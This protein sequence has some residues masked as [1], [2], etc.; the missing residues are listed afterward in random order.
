M[1]P[2]MLDRLRAPIRLM[3]LASALAPSALA[4]Q[5]PVQAFWA[6]HWNAV[7]HSF[8]DLDGDG[9]FIGAGEVQFHVDPLSPAS[10]AT[11][12]LQVTQENGQLV[13]YWVKESNDIIY[14]GVDA[15]GNGTLAGAEITVFR[16]SGVHDGSSWP[17]DID[18]T[19]DGA[20]WWTSGL[21][22]S[23]PQNGLARLEDL[24]D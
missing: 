2:P 9:T 22:L 5:Q 17:Q 21:L 4:Q 7:Y 6:D 15:N 3:L 8:T 18:V 1:T 12:A 11:I 13:T 23:Q 16:N 10:G 14:R 19:D 20:G 24:N